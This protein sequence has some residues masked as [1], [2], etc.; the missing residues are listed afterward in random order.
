MTR[1]THLIDAGWVFLGGTVGTFLR[2][3]LTLYGGHHS[4]WVL[5]AVNVIGAGALGAVFG[6]LRAGTSP[7]ARRTR[8]LVCTGLLG[9]FTSYSTFA[10]DALGFL[11]RAEILATLGYVTGTIGLSLIAA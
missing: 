7:A 9:G 11:Q 4:P 8:T 6:L 10:V 2:V 3:C 1:R 5:L